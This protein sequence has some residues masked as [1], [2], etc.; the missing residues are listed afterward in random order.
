MATRGGDAHV[1]EPDS[2][3]TVRQPGLATHN[4]RFRIQKLPDSR[5]RGTC[6]G[7]HLHDPPHALNPE[8][9]RVCHQE[10]GN[11]LSDIQRPDAHEVYAEY[12][13]PHLAQCNDD[14]RQRY[15]RRSKPKGR[16]C[17]HREFEYLPIEPGDAV[18]LEARMP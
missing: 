7:K 10:R 16:T 18:R 3:R 17:M 1:A 8:Y 9:Q 11:Q 14:L 5:G 15:A 6:I 12:Q 13:H 4:L 2:E